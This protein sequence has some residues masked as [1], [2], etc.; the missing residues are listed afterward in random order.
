LGAEPPRIRSLKEAEVV[1][2]SLWAQVRQLRRDVSDHA[3]RLD[4][5]QTHLWRRGWWWLRRG[6]PLTDWNAAR[7]NWRPWNRRRR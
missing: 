1:I 5:A 3:E 7:P 4:T 6:W 2:G